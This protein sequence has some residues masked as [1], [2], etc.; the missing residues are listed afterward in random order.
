MIKELINQDDI[1]VANLYPITALK[2]LKQ[3]LTEIKGRKR[4]NWLF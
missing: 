1:K 3:K 4:Q 2:C